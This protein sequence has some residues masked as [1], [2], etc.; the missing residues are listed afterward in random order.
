M[1]I[2]KLI[3]HYNTPAITA[4]LCEMATD[5]MIIDNGSSLDM[6]TYGLKNTV[7][8]FESNLGFTGNWNRA[9][10]FIMD[11]DE[12]TT[13]AFWLMNSD[14]Q[15]STDSIA[16]IQRLLELH[17]YDMITP[18]YNCWMKDCRNNGS[19]G[20]R[21]VNCIELTAPV[22]L[23]T[24]F[25]KIGFF[26]PIFAK[27]YGVEFDWAMRMHS[28]GLKMYCDDASVFYH[29]G[30][31]TIKSNGT[32]AAYE[33]AAVYEMNR[34]MEKY[35]G[36]NWKHLL[37]NKLNVTMNT[38][39]KSRI[40]VYTT[41]FG[42]YDNLRI[43]PKQNID[44]QYF[45]ITDDAC[46][47]APQSDEPEVMEQWNIVPVKQPRGDLCPMMRAK[48]YKLF[49]WEF[50]HLAEFDT[51]IFIDA[52]IQVDS[53]TF[54]N[55]AILNL[56]SD[57]A[58]FA[59]PDRNCIYDEAAVSLTMPKYEREDIA[60]Q[61][62][63]YANIHPAKAGLFACGMMV[64]KKTQRIQDMMGCWWHEITKFS[65][66]DQISFPVVAHLLKINPD[67]LP[68]SIFSNPYFKIVP[69]GAQVTMP[70]VAPAVSQPVSLNRND[71]MN[72]IIERMK[73]KSYL[74][75]GLRAGFTFD[76]IRC[77]IKHSI[78]PVSMPGA[79]PTFKM[80]SDVFFEQFPTAKYDMIFIDGD[81][82]HEQ[83]ARDFIHAWNTIGSY[84][85]IVLHDTNPINKRFTEFDRCG[86]AFRVLVDILR[87][88]DMPIELYT[89][90]MPDDEGNGI[91]IAF[92]GPRTT[93]DMYPRISLG[94]PHP[95]DDYE[96]F[97]SLRQ[98]ITNDIAYSDFQTVVL[99]K[100]IP[101]PSR[102]KAK[103]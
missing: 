4:A 6:T 82:H 7:L 76:A 55:F 96:V 10:K 19:P 93:K 48:W 102:K 74:E 100:C 37:K 29:L 8:R 25:E 36:A 94:V 14:I 81:H 57:I 67:I 69:H 66:Q 42:G 60:A 9:I 99:Q 34:G 3:L 45:C 20:V 71:V 68:G 72:F 50:E 89:L 17:P 5:A 63:Y 24:V 47:V 22:I 49:P 79:E 56:K 86:T 101:V 70:E 78:D 21:Q 91:S 32:L 80:L 73:Y 41:I 75:I 1:K 35:Y 13:D 83:V 28:A 16:R 61:M 54:I 51:V 46:L 12:G 92:K 43:M 44:A 40:A 31:Q 33:A 65:F 26:D 58:L 2:I 30:Q 15:I 38:R 11:R 59:H 84:G 39:P 77:D 98:L 23:R 53:P 88:A 27:G 64:R 52:N 97:D 90:T 85:C 62:I 103:K 18:S 95:C 87:W